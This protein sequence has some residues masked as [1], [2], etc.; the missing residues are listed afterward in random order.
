M[1][2]LLTLLAFCASLPLMGQ[3]SPYAVYETGNT[4]SFVSVDVT[5]GTHTT[6]AAIPGMSALVVPEKSTIDTVNNWYIV[7]GWA[8][9][10]ATIF[11]L[12]LQTGAVVHS[13]AVSDNVVGFEFNPVDGNIYGLWEN[14][15]VYS[16]VTIDVVNGTHSTVGVINGVGAYVGGS[17]S[18]D[19][20]RGWYQFMGINGPDLKL[21]AVDVTTGATVHNPLMSDNVTGQEYNCEDSTTYGVWED[22]ADYKL[23][24]MDFS[25]GTHSTVAVLTGVTPGFITESASLDAD[26]HYSFRGFLGND[27]TLFSIDVATGTVNYSNTFT[28]NV[29]AF[30]APHGCTPT[31]N[32]FPP[33]AA[34]SASSTNIM[35]GQNVDF[36]D[37]STNVPTSWEWTFTGAQNFGSTD[38]N[39]LAVIYPNEGC[40][41]V[42]LIASNFFGTDTAFESCYITVTAVSPPGFE[43]YTSIAGLKLYHDQSADQLVLS[44]PAWQ[45]EAMSL[46]LFDLTGRNVMKEGVGAYQSRLSVANLPTGVYAFSVQS[47]KGAR[48]TGRLVVR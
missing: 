27:F 40:F 41:D 44:L 46:S 10:S 24:A 9:G 15:N 22:G 23:E 20:H 37:L 28:D 17:F 26:G 32:G 16:L 45:G 33:V 1:R 8:N 36:T 35:E 29:A 7:E 14:G 5:T 13:N 30:E 34:F 31:P 6:I 48:A 19:F 39:P 21:W 25:T 3:V 12:D 2:Q 43:E 18:L 11:A 42:E 4:Y 47:S 38:Q